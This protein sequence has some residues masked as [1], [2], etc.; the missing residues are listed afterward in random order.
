MTKISI[1]I[2]VYNAES[3]LEECLNSIIC[4]DLEDIEIICVNDGSTDNSALILENYTEKDPRIIN[5]TQINGGVSQARNLGL[6]QASGDFILFVDAD[7]FLAEHS[8][9][10]LYDCTKKNDLDILVFGY[11][12]LLNDN[13]SVSAFVDIWKN[14]LP[15][16]GFSFN[17]ED[18]FLL[19][20]S[21]WNKLISK[22]LIKKRS[23]L[24]RQ[25]SV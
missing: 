7:D 14:K 25:D 9:K 19:N 1:I 2:P 8:L 24:F 12:H 15:A 20:G 3:Y 21:I 16:G 13:I 22:E 11:Y 17:F 18:S 6:K 23:N 4:Q 5:I 10:Y